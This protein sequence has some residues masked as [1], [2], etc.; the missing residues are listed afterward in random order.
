MFAFLTNLLCI[1]PL[2]SSTSCSHSC[3]VIPCRVIL[4]IINI[5]ARSDTKVSSC[6][7]DD[8]VAELMYTKSWIL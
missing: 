3:T 6:L 7:I 1:T 8:E 4:V 5:L 2:S